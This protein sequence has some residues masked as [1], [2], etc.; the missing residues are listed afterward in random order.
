MRLTLSTPA[1]SN[2]S[3]G[4]EF[5]L[6]RSLLTALEEALAFERREVWLR[7][8]TAE[9][10]ESGATVMAPSAFDGERV[11]AV[12]DTL[13]LSPR[14]FAAAL[15]VSPQTI[16]AWERGTRRPDGPALRLLEIAEGHPET[17]LA[18]VMPGAKRSERAAGAHRRVG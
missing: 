13:A 4:E 2:T 16:V 18:T 1:S 10:P 15:N 14:K 17:L 12:R 8:H 3:H 7:T 9:Y 5:N 6:E 11:R